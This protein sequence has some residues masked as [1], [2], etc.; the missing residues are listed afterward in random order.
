VEG[1]KG[2]VKGV[3]G[4][5]LAFPKGK[6]VGE[7]GL[8]RVYQPPYSPELNPAKRV[9]AE[10]RRWVEG[11]MYESMKAKQAAVGRVRRLGAGKGV[12]SLVGCAIFV[13]LS[14]L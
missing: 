13:R 1:H 4:D 14:M 2:E 5:P 7:V 3:V 11:R 12:L 9:F 10:V 6:A 8:R